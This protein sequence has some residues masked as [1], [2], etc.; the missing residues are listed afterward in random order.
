MLDTHLISIDLSLLRALQAL[1]E[2]RHISRAAERTFLPQPAMSALDSRRLSYLA[3]IDREMCERG[4]KKRRGNPSTSCV[5]DEVTDNLLGF[6]GSAI[7]EIPVHR[8][9][10]PEGL[11]D[12]SL[13]VYCLEYGRK[14]NPSRRD[15][16]ESLCPGAA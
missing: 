16:F 11:N 5:R 7:L 3:L 8:R 10:V 2:E 6:D 4:I 9:A 13:T 15:G 1:L 12:N 14:M